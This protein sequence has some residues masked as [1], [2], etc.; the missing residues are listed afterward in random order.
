MWVIQTIK[1]RRHQSYLIHDD[2]QTSSFIQRSIL[3]QKYVVVYLTFIKVVNFSL[4]HKNQQ[5]DSPTQTS[6][7]KLNKEENYWGK[8]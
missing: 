4:V 6:A 7:N 3:A 1:Y 8:K 5:S 2:L